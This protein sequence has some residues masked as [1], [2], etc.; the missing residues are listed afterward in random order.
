ME[1]SKGGQSLVG[2]PALID[3]GTH[4]EIEVFDEPESPP[5]RSIAPACAGWSPCR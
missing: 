5:P 1:V 4:V 3:K 2:F